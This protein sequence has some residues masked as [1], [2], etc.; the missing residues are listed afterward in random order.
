MNI[1]VIYN[2]SNAFYKNS[3]HFNQNSKAFDA[4]SCPFD[5]LPGAFFF[6]IRRGLIQ[7]TSA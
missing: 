3:G 7:N 2:D 4:I 6:E 1:G 5:A